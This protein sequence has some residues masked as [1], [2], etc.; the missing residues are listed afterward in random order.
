MRKIS[1][2]KFKEYCTELS[3]KHFIFTDEDQNW[4]SVSDTLR[5]KLVFDKSIISF[6]PNAINLLSHN[7]VISFERV[8]YINDYGKTVLGRVF[9]IVCGNSTNNNQD[10]TYTIVIQ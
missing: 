2:K 4:H 8:K 10:R 9:G 6:N 3:P 7:G 1:I 5:I